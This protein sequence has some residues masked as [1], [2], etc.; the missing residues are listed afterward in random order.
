LPP[1]DDAISVNIRV[2]KTDEAPAGIGPSSK[3][4]GLDISVHGIE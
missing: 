2:K 1:G 4:I 3:V